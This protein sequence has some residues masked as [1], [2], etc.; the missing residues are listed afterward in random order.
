[1]TEKI[2]AIKYGGHAL[3]DAQIREAFMKSLANLSKK[4]FKFVVV[5]GGGPA[6][7]KLLA[8][9]NIKS[10]F[11]NGLRVTTQPVLEAVEMAL[12]GAVNKEITRMFAQ[13]GVNAAGISGEDG[14]LFHAE[15]KDP[16]LGLVG[17]IVKVNPAL[18]LC[19]LENGFTP[20]VAPLALD[21][22]YRPLNVNADTA[23]GALAGALH[24]EL[25]VLVS[26]V[27]GVLDANGRLLEKLDQ[28]GIEKLL[29][30]GVISGGM[31]PKVE[32][33]LSALAAGCQKAVILDGRAE[34][35][36]ERLLETLDKPDAA[37][38]AGTFI[39]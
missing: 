16:A 27:P 37:A 35:S 31:I 14:G 12:C 38:P 10:E 33:C 36:L 30:S 2:I 13:A 22:D 3:D 29:E 20:V 32:A 9:L 25:F 11:A 18:P 26:D 6:I 4:G 17:K 1:M 15:Q 23:A 7:N 5:H 24:A 19:L 28:A 39:M 34:G 8:A 21:K